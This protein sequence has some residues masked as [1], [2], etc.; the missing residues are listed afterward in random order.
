MT[1]AE[2]PAAG[3]CQG[4]LRL[5]S[6]LSQAEQREAL[7]TVSLRPERGEALVVPARGT[8]ETCPRRLL[9]PQKARIGGAHYWVAEAPALW[10]LAVGGAAEDDSVTVPKNVRA[11]AAS[12][13]AGWSPASSRG[14][15]RK[16]LRVQLQRKGA[17]AALD[18]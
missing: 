11:A 6:Q 13:L 17:V 10:D 14:D 18:M 3:G 12:A 15:R 2:P 8:W 5:W 9:E 7:A 4:S 1:G 16:A